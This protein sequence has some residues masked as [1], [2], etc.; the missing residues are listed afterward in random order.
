MP[1]ENR[2]PHLW[3]A[4][5]GVFYIRSFNGGRRILRSTGERD[6]SRAQAALAQTLIQL[7]QPALPAE[8]KVADVLSAYVEARAATHGIKQLAS[9]CRIVSARLGWLQPADVAQAHIR[10]YA[11]A[12]AKQGIG[13][14]T[15]R[16]ELAYLRAALRW[17]AAEALIAPPRPFS[18]PAGAPPRARWLTQAECDALIAAAVEP[19]VRLY[20]M[21]AL[22][23]GARSS[24]IMELP[25]SAVDIERRIVAYPAKQGGKRRV[26]VPIN[27]P[28]LAELLPARERSVTKWVIEYAA[29]PVSTMRSGWRNTLRRSGIAH[30]TRHDL[31]RTAG[32]LMIQRG[33]P[34]E[35][36]A[37]VLGHADIAIT[38]S[39]YAWLLAEHL[40]SAVAALDGRNAGN[41]R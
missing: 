5:T 10:S 30:C 4:A 8:P 6:R 12:R 34:I 17:A 39:T 14:G 19:H 24:A 41:G 31:R 37:A 36:V 15:V 22:H 7:D 20:L 13:R 29:Q 21:L 27:E 40:R 23:T 28:L 1:R 38:R 9:K 11:A 2:G 3:R 32:S 16:V 18:L 33:V 35:L 26:A 25:W